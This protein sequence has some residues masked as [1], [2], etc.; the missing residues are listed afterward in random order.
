MLSDSKDHFDNGTTGT[1]I[2]TFNPFTLSVRTPHG[3]LPLNLK[4]PRTTTNP[5]FEWSSHQVLPLHKDLEEIAACTIW[6]LRRLAIENIDGLKHLKPLFETCPK[7]DPIAI[8][9]TEQYPLPAMHIEE[10]SIE[11]T[12][13]V[14]TTI[15]QNLGMTNNDLLKHGLLFNDGDLL[16]DSLVNAVCLFKHWPSMFLKFDRLKVLN[17]Q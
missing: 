7:V 6:Q 9:T 11:G 5:T 2:P 16:T 15:L 17:V 13:H 14:Y 8:H 12:I 4:P 3:T 1:A 10:S